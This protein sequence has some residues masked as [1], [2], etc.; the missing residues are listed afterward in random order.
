MNDPADVNNPSPYKNELQTEFAVCCA[1]VELTDRVTRLEYYT[2][3]KARWFQSEPGKEIFTIIREYFETYGDIP[4]LA[5]LES[6]IKTD[7]TREQFYYYLSLNLHTR[8]FSLEEFSACLTRLNRLYIANNI[9]NLGAKGLNAYHKEGDDDALRHN[10]NEAQQFIELQQESPIQEDLF[11]DHMD[12]ILSPKVG[13]EDCVPSTFAAI[14]DVYGGFYRRGAS[15]IAADTGVGKTMLSASLALEQALLGYRVFYA[16]V[17]IGVQDI[18]NRIIANIAEY[19]HNKLR[20]RPVRDG[21]GNL[22]P[23][24]AP[25]GEERDRLL[26]AKCLIEKYIKEERFMLI[27]PRKPVLEDILMEAL[28]RRADIVYIDPVGY[29]KPSKIS[30][31]GGIATEWYAHLLTLSRDWADV[32]NIP[33]VLM[34]HSSGYGRQAKC[35]YSVRMADEAD[36]TMFMSVARDD[37]AEDLD[38]VGSERI[39]L[40]VYKSRGGKNDKFIYLGC[41]WDTQRVYNDL[42][43]GFQEYTKS[44]Q[45]N[46]AGEKVGGR[47]GGSIYQKPVGSMSDLGDTMKAIANFKW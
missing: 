25:E 43:P 47:K 11:A 39:E 15:L 4:S 36:F 21:Q 41:H 8:L 28:R 29:I 10:I 42:T 7:E 26:N 16:S 14:D 46:I 12:K 19:P 38:K 1:L 44:A 20:L 9:Y 24:R 3:I 5:F 33:V 23:P 13:D 30:G 17:E 6:N 40:Y 45:A 35:R 27:H 18:Y 34:A 37:S 2:K 32:H 22:I 31:E